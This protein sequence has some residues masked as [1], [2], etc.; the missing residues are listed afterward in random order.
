M[1]YGLNALNVISGVKKKDGALKRR[2][3]LMMLAVE[4]SNCPDG[5]FDVGRKEAA[6]GCSCRP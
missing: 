1:R 6:A 4:P 5:L 3:V 2:G